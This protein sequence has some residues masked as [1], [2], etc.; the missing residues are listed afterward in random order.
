MLY[1]RIAAA[2]AAAP[3]PKA[4]AAP[5][6]FFEAPPVNMGIEEEELPEAPGVMEAEGI[7]IDPEGIIPA[8]IPAIPLLMLP[9]P[10]MLLMLLMPLL[11]ALLVPVAIPTYTTYG[12]SHGI[13]LKKKV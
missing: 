6:R 7:R 4:P 1:I 12:V 3:T 2:A 8:P 5:F 10:L 11:I 9:M 13:L